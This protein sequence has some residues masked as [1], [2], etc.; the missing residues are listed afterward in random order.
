MAKRAKKPAPEKQE[1]RTAENEPGLESVAQ[2]EPG[3]V[4]DEMRALLRLAVQEERMT[5]SEPKKKRR[6]KA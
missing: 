3:P 2:R 6:K 4:T 5:G 1:A